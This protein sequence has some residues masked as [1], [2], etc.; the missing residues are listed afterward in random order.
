MHASTKPARAVLEDV[1]GG[2]EATVEGIEIVGATIGEASLGVCPNGLVRIELRSVG[3]KE[4]EVETRVTATKRPHRFALVDRGIVQKD[5]Q[6]AAQVAQEMVEEV[7]DVALPNVVAVAAE[8]K[9]YLPAH[10]ADRDA[11]DDREA[12]VSVA[13]VDARRLTTRRPGPPQGRDQEEARFVDEDEVRPPARCVF[14]TCGQ[15]VRFQ[16]SMRPSSRS[17]ARRPGFWGLRPS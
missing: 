3:R 11:G 6:V 13:V 1:A 5:D 10:G 15:R 4:L 16:C 9:S 14:F 8:V 17:S 2:V 7:A 12:I